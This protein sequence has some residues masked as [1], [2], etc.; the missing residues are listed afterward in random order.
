MEMAVA[1]G[2]EFVRFVPA[3]VDSV[4]RPVT[5]LVRKHRRIGGRGHADHRSLGVRPFA[6]NCAAFSRS[7]FQGDFKESG[8]RETGRK[9]VSFGSFVADTVVLEDRMADIGCDFDAVVAWFE[10]GCDSGLSNKIIGRESFID[11]EKFLM[12]D[13]PRLEMANDEPILEWGADRSRA[14]VKCVPHDRVLS[15]SVRIED[16][17]IFDDEVGIIGERDEKRILGPSDVIAFEEIFFDDICVVGHDEHVKFA[18]DS[19]RKANGAVDGVAFARAE[20]SVSLVNPE[21]EIVLVS[22][23]GIAGKDGAIEP[24][25]DFGRSAADVGNFERE[26]EVVAALQIWRHGDGEVGY[27]QIRE[28]KVAGWQDVDLKNVFA[29]K[30]AGVAVGA[31]KGKIFAALNDLDL[32]GSVEGTTARGFRHVITI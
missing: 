23:N 20:N 2:S 15:R 7:R 27:L 3:A 29:E 19:V 21:L 9:G 17:Q 1:N 26:I 31:N 25:A 4:F 10:N 24:G 12:G 18:R 5:E 8:D 13:G 22:I 16:F 32:G 6:G 11:F 30:I 14:A 28:R